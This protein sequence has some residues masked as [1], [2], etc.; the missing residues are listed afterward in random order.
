[1]TGASVTLTGA[2][3]AVDGT[4]AVR[5]ELSG[6]AADAA[7]VGRQLALDLLSRGAGALLGAAR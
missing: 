4:S 1:M 7:L 5:G 3:I 6:A 2:V